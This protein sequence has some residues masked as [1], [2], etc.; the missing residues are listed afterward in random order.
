MKVF[1]LG[2]AAVSAMVRTD[3]ARATEEPPS[4]IGNFEFH[5]CTCGVASFVGR[6]PWEYHAA[7]ELLHVLAGRTELTIRSPSG[8]ETRTLRAG[9]LTIVPRQCWHNNDAP[10]GV[11]MLFMTPSEGSRHSW[12]DPVDPE[13]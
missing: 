6:P 5:G 3:L 11:T 12:D 13:R 7:D 10:T 1:D 2:D 9:D 4:A 8:E